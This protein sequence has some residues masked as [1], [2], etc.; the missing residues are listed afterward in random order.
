MKLSTTTVSRVTT[1]VTRLAPAL[2]ALALA[3]ATFAQG[4]NSGPRQPKID[5]VP[6]PVI[7]YALLAVMAIAILSISLYPSKRAH[8]DL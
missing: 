8:S 2:M 3:S 6:S 1:F 5:S 7:G 4:I